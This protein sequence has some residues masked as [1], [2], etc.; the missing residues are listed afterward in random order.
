MSNSIDRLIVQVRPFEPEYALSAELDPRTRILSLSR[1][2]PENWP[3]GLDLSAKV[4]IDFD[5]HGRLAGL[6]LMVPPSRWPTGTITVPETDGYAT[7]AINVIL[8]DR[9]S[10]AIPVEICAEGNRLLLHW[11]PATASKAVR[12][13]D[14][15]T[16]LLSES[17]WVGILIENF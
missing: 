8:R 10:Y 2:S 15:A 5:G 16:A 6:E 11:G 7:V 12:I 17:L 14:Q 9:S 13:S 4:L 3:F 1:Q